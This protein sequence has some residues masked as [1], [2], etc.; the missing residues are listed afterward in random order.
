MGLV[1]C[2]GYIESVCL[3]VEALVGSS[4]LVTGNDLLYM[5]S[6]PMPVGKS[7]QEVHMEKAD[8]QSMF[9]KTAHEDREFE[10]SECERKY[11]I[12]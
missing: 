5:R 1:F 3:R 12:R 4:S 10:R 9:T 8:L 6:Q 11:N 2:F 7:Y